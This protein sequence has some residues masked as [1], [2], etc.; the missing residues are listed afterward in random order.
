MSTEQLN[1]LDNPLRD[2]T[3][4]GRNPPNAEWPNGARI[5]VS[6]VLNY[7]EGGEYT[8]LNGDSRTESILGEKFGTV[9]MSNGQ[10]DWTMESQFE[11]GSRAGVWRIMNLFDKHDMKITI[12]AV[13]RALEVNPIAAPEFEKHGHE[14]A[15]HGYRWIE[16]TDYE[17]NEEA[18][19]QLVR[20]GIE[21]I[22]KCA[23]SG[24][25]PAGWYLGRPSTKSRSLIAQ[26]HKEMGIPL[27]WQSDS[28]ADDL[29]YWIPYPGGAKSEGLLMIPYSYDNNDFKFHT[30]PGWTSTDGFLQH[31]VNAF[32]T[33]YEEGGKMMSIGLHC[34][35]VGKPG[36]FPALKK[37]VEYISK[38]E[39]V[40]VTTRSQIA[41][42]WTKKFPYNPEEVK[43]A[44]VFDKPF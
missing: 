39:G 24:K 6:F 8:P 33:L 17:G 14:L 1:S 36:R 31:L 21:A 43:F 26:V 42:H 37:F 13:G 30:P 41:E 11:Y 23:P 18:E 10:R 15:M 40:W 28:Y 44:P 38:K 27:K 20:R 34:R 35:I 25:P 3:G 29:P 12:Y 16:H 9:P 2:F 32:D 4:Y 5:A 22:Q 19:K 7:E